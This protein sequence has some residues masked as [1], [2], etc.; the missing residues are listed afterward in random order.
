MNL[1]PET[2][3]AAARAA[4]DAG[5]TGPAFELFLSAGAQMR[6]RWRVEQTLNS[7]LTAVGAEFRSDFL[8][9]ATSEWL[10]EFHQEKLQALARAWGMM[11]LDLHGVG[12]PLGVSGDSTERM[13]PFCDLGKGRR[14]ASDGP[15]WMAAL[16]GAMDYVH[17]LLPG[18]SMVDGSQLRLS[19]AE[20]DGSPVLAVRT[21]DGWLSFPANGRFVGSFAGAVLASAAGLM[22]SP[23]EGADVDA[24]LE[25]WGALFNSTK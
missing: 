14:K 24:S 19:P 11:A 17:S 9:G 5:L 12:G 20:L 3:S 1:R 23:P 8:L 18:P 13:S 6:H 21:A 25:E 22:E 7:A 2:R 15:A 16:V 10:L 4:E